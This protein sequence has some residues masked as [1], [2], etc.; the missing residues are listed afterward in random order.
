MLTLPPLAQ[1]R[2]T[3]EDHFANPAS[4]H[5]GPLA[6]NAIVISALLVVSPWPTWAELLTHFRVSALT[7]I[8]KGLLITRAVTAQHTRTITLAPKRIGKVSNFLRPTHDPKELV[9]PYGLRAIVLLIRTRGMPV[10][11]S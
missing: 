4:L 3:V 1:P 11:A 7:P 10:P 9:A 2:R 8:N 5:V 6:W